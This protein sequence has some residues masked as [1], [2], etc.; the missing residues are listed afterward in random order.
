MRSVEDGQP[1][2]DPKLV[3]AGQVDDHAPLR[4]LLASRVTYVAATSSTSMPVTG[5]ESSIGDNAKS[6]A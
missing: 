4:Q 3:E 1:G 5:P 2:C 6:L